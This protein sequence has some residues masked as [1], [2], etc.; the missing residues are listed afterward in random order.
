LGL[1]NLGDWDINLSG[2]SSSSINGRVY[3]ALPFCLFQEETCMNTMRDEDR[4]VRRPELLARLKSF[5]GPLMLL[6]VTGGIATGKS[7]VAGM[8]EEMGARTIDFDVLSREVV[9]PGKPAYQDILSFF[10]EQ[11]LS[12]D[13][14]ID[15]KRLKE[16][17]FQDR[18]KLRK[19]ESFTHPRIWD[20]FLLQVE[21]FSREKGTVI[22]QAV[23]PLLIETNMQSLFDHLLMVYVPEEVQLKRLIKR[24]GISEELAGNIIRSQMSVEGKKRCCDLMVDNSGSSEQTRHQV[25][26]IWRKLTQNLQDRKKGKTNPPPLSGSKIMEKCPSES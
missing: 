8:L 18:E 7:I 10:G 12:A 17:V 26:E 25:E 20:E 13:K 9:K 15:R 5:S 19:L 16:I 21:G 1:L 2:L 14:N 4:S 22:I 11:V 3:S 6:G 24:D 23:V